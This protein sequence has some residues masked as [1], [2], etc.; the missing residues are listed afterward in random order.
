MERE[1]IINK[2]YM[3]LWYHP[4]SKI[5]HHK[6]KKILPDG[7]HEELLSTGAECMEKHGATKWLSDDSEMV[8][9]REEANKWAEEVWLPRVLKAGFKYWA[10]VKPNSSVFGNMQITRFAK[11][12]REKGIAAKIFDTVEQ[13]IVWL[14]SK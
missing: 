9:V 14:E 5:V 4:A 3:E 11:E 6:M 10:I 13:A 1:Q 8:V 12:Y 7:G 2:D